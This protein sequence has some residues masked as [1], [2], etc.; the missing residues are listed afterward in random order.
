[1]TSALRLTLRTLQFMAPAL[2]VLNKS[3]L[4]KK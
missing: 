2:P 4:S 1:M 3:G